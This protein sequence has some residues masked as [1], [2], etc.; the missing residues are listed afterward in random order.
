MIRGFQ[1]SLCRGHWDRVVWC[2]DEHGWVCRYCVELPH[3]IKVWRAM[4]AHKAEHE[5]ERRQ[6]RQAYDDQR[7]KQ[8]LL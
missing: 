7:Q 6:Q 3:Y 4:A 2:G 8:R 1:C 5:S